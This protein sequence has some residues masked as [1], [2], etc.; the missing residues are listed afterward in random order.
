MV[1]DQNKLIKLLFFLCLLSKLCSSCVNVILTFSTI[2]LKLHNVHF[3]KLFLSVTLRT[4]RYVENDF[5]FNV[6]YAYW[7]KV[8]LTYI[9][10]YHGKKVHF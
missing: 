1:L 2:V 7:L 10:F 3:L 4:R 6:R 9:L 5:L 8:L